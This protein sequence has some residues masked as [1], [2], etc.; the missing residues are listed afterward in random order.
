MFSEQVSSD[1]VVVGFPWAA[2]ERERSAKGTARGWFSGKGIVDHPQVRERT[3]VPAGRSI[4][5]Q[6]LQ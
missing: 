2:K 5:G 3:T 1:E 4:A 6:C